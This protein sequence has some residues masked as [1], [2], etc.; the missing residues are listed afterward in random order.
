MR[1]HLLNRGVRLRPDP[2]HQ[3]IR[4]YPLGQFIAQL[5]YLLI[6]DQLRITV[7]DH[8]YHHLEESIALKV[9]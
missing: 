6:S 3:R 4:Q 9:E 8:G 2:C 5:C 1:V 7:V